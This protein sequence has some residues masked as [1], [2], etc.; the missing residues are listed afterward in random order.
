MPSTPTRTREGRKGRPQKGREGGREGGRTYRQGTEIAVLDEGGHL[1][2]ELGVAEPA[3][4]KVR[5][6][7]DGAIADIGHQSLFQDLYVGEAWGGREGGREGRREGGRIKRG[8]GESLFLDL[9]VLSG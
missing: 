9:A 1:G 6:G 4:I 5:D 2:A 3:Y 7:P 8:C